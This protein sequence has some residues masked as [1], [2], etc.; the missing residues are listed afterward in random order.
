[1]TLPPLVRQAT[2]ARLKRY[3]QEKQAMVPPHAATSIRYGYKFRG[4][5]AT[6]FTIRPVFMGP[7]VVTVPC[8]QF[9]FD[10]DSGQWTLYCPDRNSRWHVYFDADPTRDFEALLQEVDADPTG[11]F[12]G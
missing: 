9:R 5:T 6:L 3:C 8:A 10:A 2:E 7:G 11:I 4:A 1:M 12:W